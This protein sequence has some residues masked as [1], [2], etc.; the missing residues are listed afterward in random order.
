MKFSVLVSDTARKFLQR[1]PAKERERIKKGL[2]CLSEDPFTSRPNADI[3]KLQGKKR[4]YYRLRIGDFRAIY[5]VEENI[6]R[7]AY[8]MIRQ[9]DYSWLD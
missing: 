9:K 6:V 4:D 3:K 2:S 5:I 7:V 8:I 1:R